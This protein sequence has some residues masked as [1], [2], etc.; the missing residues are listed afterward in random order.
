MACLHVFNK[1][2]NFETMSKCYCIKF[3]LPEYE[4]IVALITNKQ[5][6]DE[7]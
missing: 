4:E 3:I 5:S 6:V 2:Y 1:Y 7:M